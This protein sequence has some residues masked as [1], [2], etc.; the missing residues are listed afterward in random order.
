M[1]NDDENDTDIALSRLPDILDE[2]KSDNK[3]EFAQI[4]SGLKQIL[5]ASPGASMPGAV[6]LF[7]N[8]IV[9]SP[10]IDVSLASSTGQ[11]KINKAGWYDVNAALSLDAPGNIAMALFKNGVYI[12][13]STFANLCVH[14]DAGDMLTLNNASPNQIEVILPP[15]VNA[16]PATSA[17]LKIFMLR[18]DEIFKIKEN[19]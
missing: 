14:F 8:I 13:N 9:A 15:S 19:H 2:V 18:E 17:F 1:A 16:S 3:P 5:A 6:V 11:V 12:P 10:N 7:E 4:C